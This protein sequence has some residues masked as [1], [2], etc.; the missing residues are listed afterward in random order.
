MQY[1]FILIRSIW[2]GFAIVLATA[3][4]QAQSTPQLWQ[5]KG[6]VVSAQGTGFV[7]VSIG[8]HTAQD[9]TLIKGTVTDSLGRFE[10]QNIKT[11]QYLLAGNSANGTKIYLQKLSIDSTT[12]T[13][14]DLG[15]LT[16]TD[17][18]L[19]LA[20][21]TITA[22]KPFIERRADRLI[23]NI[24][25]SALAKGNNA[26]EVLKIIPTLR[27]GVD[28][29]ISV[30][31][32]GGVLILI[33]GKP[34]Y[35]MGIQELKGM[36]GESIEK[37]EIYS[38]PPAKF[39]AQGAAVINVITQKSKMYSSF[40]ETLAMPFYPTKN[41]SG[42]KYISNFSDLTLYY[43]F[44]KLKTK[45]TL[46]WRQSKG[47]FQMGS[48]ELTYKSNGVRRIGDYSQNNDNKSLRIGLGL[49]YDFDK[50]N[51]LTFDMR[52]SQA[53]KGSFYDQF[54][55]YQ[56]LS[57]L[58]RIDST[59]VTNS[60]TNYNT[61]T[62][63]LYGGYIHKF[64]E[65]KILTLGIQQMKYNY[66]TP[67]SYQNN[68]QSNNIISVTN[69]DTY[70]NRIQTVQ[71]Y[72]LNVELPTTKKYLWEVGAKL[73]TV[74][75][76]N[77]FSWFE[78]KEN[79][80]TE[81]LN[82]QNNFL[83]KENIWAGF[84]SVRKTF[85]KIELSA[86]LRNEYTNS[87]GSSDGK[88][89]STSYNN[90]FPSFF[91]QYTIAE[92]KQ[93]GFSYTRRVQRPSY[94]EFNPKSLPFLGLLNLT[95]GNAYL[96]PQFINALEANL[97]VKDLYMAI[98]FN[99]TEKKRIALPVGT[100]G[101][102]IVNQIFNLAYLDNITFSINKP[103]QLTSWW[104]ST[105][106]VQYYYQQAKLLDN[107][108]IKATFWDMSTQHTFTLSPKSQIEAF[109]SYSSPSV[110]QYTSS[111]SI[112]SLNIAYKTAFL[113]KKLDLT[114][115]VSDILGINK[116]TFYSD[117]PLMSDSMSSVT[118]SR[119]I[120]LAMTYKFATTTKF[121]KKGQKTSDFGEVR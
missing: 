10:F 103:F 97:L 104:Q 109:F 75:Y 61:Q 98:S 49:D 100:E 85:D 120:R 68:S 1:N 48:S 90:L 30:M 31:G 21:V 33:D 81:N 117:T 44:G 102:A 115:N 25:G 111:S 50:N 80:A 28:G 51:S 52:G 112:Q 9:S 56:Y 34:Q 7:F 38:N 114:I 24:S 63:N 87:V 37:V 94:N 76:Q 88:E 42:T 5:V 67:V 110:E 8:L 4:L 62:L 107:S 93:L 60:R 29:E 6:Q 106:S 23:A 19:Q 43:Q 95:T 58:G 16:L 70:P 32:K 17:K 71:S 92:E 3:F 89:V 96:T 27:V 18:T 41:I 83:Y 14:Y 82:Y 36:R 119:S 12:A 57:P 77:T 72:N 69:I 99:R 116:F 26:L 20:E 53:I 84:A 45:T 40:T 64:K 79:K 11:G 78:T 15:K 105:N 101:R 108:V 22:K 47:D 66:L 113:N 39:D 59:F 65:N 46:G 74:N 35:N 2:T 55:N 86:G 121:N 73:T 118:N 13:N 54:N 91:F